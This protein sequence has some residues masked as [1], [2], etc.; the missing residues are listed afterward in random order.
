MNFA[1]SPHTGHRRSSGG[2]RRSLIKQLGLPHPA[3]NTNGAATAQTAET[4]LDGRVLSMPDW[5]GLTLQHTNRSILVEGPD[6]AIRAVSTRAA[7]T[8]EVMQLS[9][10]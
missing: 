6:L 8:R 9:Y 5:V 3:T 7:S 2:D 1:G 4:T 10:S